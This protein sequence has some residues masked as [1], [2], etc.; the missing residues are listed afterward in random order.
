MLFRWGFVGAASAAIVL[1]ASVVSLPGAWAQGPA[2]GVDSLQSYVGGLAKVEVSVSDVGPPGVGA[3]TIDL[4]F[5]PEMLTGVECTPQ[6]GGGIC[7]EDY[8][9]GIA[10]V[11]GTDIYG[12]EGDAALAS[13]AFTCKKPGES[14]L[15]L[16]ISVFVD[17]TPG[18]PTDIDAKIV[19][20]TAICSDEPPPAPTATPPGSG[21]KIAG[22]AN[23]DS[24]VNAVDAVLVLQYASGL[25]F[26]FP[27][28]DNADYNHDGV[29]DALDAAL[30]L[31]KDAGLI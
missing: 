28:A 31:Q 29:V 20:G 23:C 25:L 26:L 10:R 16:T 21:P 17:A 22:D 18:D 15:E 19:N 27:C 7:N 9:P 24:Y 13:M 6:A 12:L 14:A 1:A 4:H 30:I 5:D 11:V 2:I 8:R 3:W